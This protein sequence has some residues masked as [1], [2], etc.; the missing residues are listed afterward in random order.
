MPPK[1][2]MN[3]KRNSG[4]N[5]STSEPNVPPRAVDAG[6]ASGLDPEAEDRFELELC[7][8][9]QQLEASLA[10][11]KL[12]M[13]QAQ[14]LSRQLNSLKSNT[15]SLIRK[16]QIMRN[17]LGDYREKMV[18][19]ERKF[20]KTVSAVK[21]T[22]SASADRKSIFVK[23]ATGRG[24]QDSKMDDKRT[25]NVLQSAKQA[26]GDRPHTPFRFNFQAC[27]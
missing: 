13:K 27:Q 7:W 18:E 5:K 2:A 14:E 25:Q 8:C 4:S 3:S 16:R 15:A 17:T 21:F 19:D 1:P 12:Q 24:I 10:A 9:I 26:D 6:N 11:G 23:K 20:G 22:S